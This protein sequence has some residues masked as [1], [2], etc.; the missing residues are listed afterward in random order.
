[1]GGAKITSQP[2]RYLCSTEMVVGDMCMRVESKK[3]NSQAGVRM[4]RKEQLRNAARTNTLPSI[5]IF[6]T[7]KIMPSRDRT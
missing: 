6:D 3:Y 7:L 4:T 2:K 5:L 1:M